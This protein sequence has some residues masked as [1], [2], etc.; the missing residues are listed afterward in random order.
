L[1]LV[2][3]IERHSRLPLSVL[4]GLPGQMRNYVLGLMF[5]D[6][7]RRRPIGWYW[8][9]ELPRA[10]AARPECSMILTRTS[11]SQLKRFMRAGRWIHIPEWVFGEVDLP[12]DARTLRRVN[13]DIRRIRKHQLSY[14]ITR[15]RRSFDDFY[16]NM[17]VPYISKTFGNTAYVYSYRHQK[18]LFHFCDLILIKQEDRVIAG[19]FIWYDGDDPPF[20]ESVG[21]RDGDRQH[22]QNGA[23][24][25]LYHFAYQYLHEQGYRTV[26]VGWSKPFL[27]DGVLQFKRKWG[28]VITYHRF[29]GTGLMVASLTPATKSFLCNNPFIF[30]RDDLLYAAVF[31]DA[32]KPLTADDLQEIEKDY[33]HA[34]LSGLT[35]Y[36]LPSDDGSASNP[37]VAELPEHVELRAWPQETN[38]GSGRTQG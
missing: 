20:L 32:D 13:G 3:G 27:N 23:A 38:A 18:R 31:V 37:A 1:W 17:Y 22:V 4:C 16:Y 5:E 14:E 10:I 26:T 19:Q 34:G 8:L 33:L 6:G 7:Y 12:L 2:E 28:E 35:I 15:D 9:W 36:R 25:A 29:W 30:K 11:E 21:I 24:C